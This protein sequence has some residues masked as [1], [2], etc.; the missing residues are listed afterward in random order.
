MLIWHAEGLFQHGWSGKFDMSA[1]LMALPDTSFEKCRRRSPTESI[2][3]SSER[4]EAEGSSAQDLGSARSASMVTFRCIFVMEFC[5]AGD[6]S[7]PLPVYSCS[8]C[9]QVRAPSKDRPSYASSSHG[10]LS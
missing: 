10:E 2:T 6:C 1:N 9:M 8:K 5:D 4:R 3:G 7:P